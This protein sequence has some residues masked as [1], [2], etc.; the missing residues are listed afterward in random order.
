MLRDTH[1]Q[2]PGLTSAV[3][4]QMP[5]TQSSS[6]RNPFLQETGEL[7]I[8][9]LPGLPINEDFKWEG[10]KSTGDRNSHMV[11]GPIQ[12]GAVDAPEHRCPAK[13]RQE[14]ASAENHCLH[15]SSCQGSSSRQSLLSFLPGPHRFRK[16]R[17]KLVEVQSRAQPDMAEASGHRLVGSTP[18][19]HCFLLAF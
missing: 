4:L 18:S 1:T 2:A 10:T 8:L 7:C 6:Q 15:Q 5:H 19:L 3:H 16:M 11:P 17:V 14:E 12:K 13:N 9:W